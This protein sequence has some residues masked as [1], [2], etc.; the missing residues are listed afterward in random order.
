MLLL[1]LLCVACAPSPTIHEMT[2]QAWGTTYHIKIVSEDGEFDENAA[3][4]K[5]Q[6]TLDEVDKTLSNWNP[7]SEVS[8]FN[9]LMAQDTFTLS[10]QLNTVIQASQRV[11]KQSEGH[12]DLTLA[13][14]I[15]LWGFGSSGTDKTTTPNPPTDAAIA[16]AME[17]VGQDSVLEHNAAAF[18][19]SKIKPQANVFLSALAKGAGIDAINAA[20]RELGHDNYLIEVGGDLI[21]IGSGP[22]GQGWRIAIEQPSIGIRELGTVVALKDKAMATSGDYR[23]YFEKDGTRFSHI[24]DPKTGRP[25]THRTASVTVLCDKAM[26]ADAWATALLVAGEETGMAIAERENIPALFISRSERNDASEFESAAS[27]AFERLQ[28]EP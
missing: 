6:R 17:N 1:S 14:V 26:L 27:T 3:K 12:F 8:R 13:P 21:A 5:L 19:L 7:D 16:K 9:A 4:A 22:A 2:G 25:I 24:I 11:H 28:L 15:E 10:P 20:L 23:N 18:S